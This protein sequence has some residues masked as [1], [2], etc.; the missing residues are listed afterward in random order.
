MSPADAR[1]ASTLVLGAIF[2]WR[3]YFT[4]YAGAAAPGAGVAASGKGKGKE[5]KGKVE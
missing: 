2:A 5:G 1:A 4:H 3:V